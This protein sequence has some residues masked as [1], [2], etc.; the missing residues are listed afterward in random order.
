MLFRRVLALFA[1]LVAASACT[2]GIN[3]PQT[4]A[5]GPQELPPE[6]AREVGAIYV[7]PTLQSFVDRVGQRVVSSSGLP[8]PYR[9][10][11]L[12]D[13]VP[14]A[15]A[16]SS[17]YIFVTRGLLAVIDD[18]AELAAAFG[19]ELGH[20][21]RK[22][23]AQ[24]ERVRR[25]M[26]EA[27]VSAA[28]ASGSVTVGRSVARE[29]LL[30]LRRYS[31]DQEL[32]ADRVGVSLLGRAGYRG[33]AMATL[34]DKLELESRLE[35]ELMGLAAD[36]G[37]RNAFAT[38]PDPV[39]RLLALKELD[40][41]SK[42]GESGREAYLAAV[43]GMSVDD[44][45]EEGFVRGASFL[46]PTMR[47]AFSAPSDFTLF[48]DHDGVLGVGRDRSLLYFSCTDETV[49]GPLADWMRNEL[50][51]TPNGIEATT[52]GGAE[53]AIGARPRGS[54]TGLE[55]IRYVLIRRDTGICYFNLLSDGP[56]RDRR[57][58]RLVDAVRSFHTLS[59]QEVAAL[60]PYRLRVVPTAG[61]TAA[62]LA[63]R[64]PYAD[65]RMLRLLTLN[66]V[67]QPAALLTRA[68]VKIVE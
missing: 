18:E 68:Q 43:D 40:G 37:E 33:T 34:I 65:H 64:L 22:H 20:L 25:A 21:T 11:I 58:D 13:P 15:H 10:F 28:V 46:H 8:G 35:N 52:I 30:A 4:A 7:S 62:L 14:N 23:A 9:F 12:D 53:A 55:Q 66:G 63:Q 38:H 24:R 48:N 39:D 17:G 67:E 26:N 47:F 29:G 42:P 61:T 5:P 3:P 59:D 49:K 32:E 31:R 44:S 27:A 41:A 1:L 51:P 60:K 50:K 16:L 45:P 54:D 2:T 57:I 19:H 6:L 36:A 56:D